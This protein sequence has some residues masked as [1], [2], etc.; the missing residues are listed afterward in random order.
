[1]AAGDI[2]G[3]GLADIVTGAGFGGGPH[4]K[5]FDGQ[6]GA[7]LLASWPM[8]PRS[9][10]ASSSPPVDWKPGPLLLISS[11]APVKAAGRTCRF[12]MDLV[13]FCRASSPTTRG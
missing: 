11:P 1:M 6:T 13:L 4:V 5:A 9:E 10:A 2:N 8:T 7:R 12:S 3:N